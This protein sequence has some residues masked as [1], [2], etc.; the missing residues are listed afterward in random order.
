MNAG[1]WQQ[2]PVREIKNRVYTVLHAGYTDAE[3]LLK[4]SSELLAA[5][6]TNVLLGKN[7]Q[8]DKSTCM[9]MLTICLLHFSRRKHSRKTSWSDVSFP[10]EPTW[11]AP[12][13]PPWGGPVLCDGSICLAHLVFTE[14]ANT[15]SGRGEGGVNMIYKERWWN[16]SR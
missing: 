12:P 7:K 3:T 4:S 8:T 1:W 16:C 15:F 9:T 13:P 2:F 11:K 14:H 6:Q 5:S 10:I